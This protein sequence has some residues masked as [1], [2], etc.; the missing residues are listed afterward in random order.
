[1]L[2]SH[3]SMSN[4]KSYECRK[5][6]KCKHYGNRQ[7]GKIG[8][9]LQKKTCFERDEE[10]P[11]HQVRVLYQTLKTPRVKLSFECFRA[12][13]LLSLGLNPRLVKEHKT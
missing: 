11:V 6:S 9:R 12:D 10:E 5:T 1:M 7:K 2:S 3:T 8:R 13:D 4:H